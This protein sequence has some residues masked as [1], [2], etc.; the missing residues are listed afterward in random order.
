MISAKKTMARDEE[1]GADEEKG[2][3]EGATWSAHA[4]LEGST[5]GRFVASCTALR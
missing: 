2:Q 4:T 5:H 1:E 3:E